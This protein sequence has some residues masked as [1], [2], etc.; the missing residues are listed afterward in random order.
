MSLFIKIFSVIILFAALLHLSEN[1]NFLYTFFIPLG[2]SN[3]SKHLDAPLLLLICLS[4]P[5]VFKPLLMLTSISQ[6]LQKS[7]CLSI[8]TNVSPRVYVYI[9]PS[10]GVIIFSLVSMRGGSVPWYL[11]AIFFS[12]TNNGYKYCLNFFRSF[13]GTPCFA[14]IC[15][16]SLAF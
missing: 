5:V 16:N 12:L 14:S 7:L 4:L 10:R 6:R 3:F 8:I 15:E 1:S 2:H 11:T 13:P 9:S